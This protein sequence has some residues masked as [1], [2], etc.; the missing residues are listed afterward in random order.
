MVA[1]ESWRRLYPDVGVYHLRCCSSDH[2]PILLKTNVLVE[3]VKWGY[4]FK[5][6]A[7]WQDHEDYKQVIKDGWE[8]AGQSSVA[9]RIR[10]CDEKLR[11]WSK[12]TFGSL[13]ARRIKA[14]KAL[15]KIDKMRKNEAILAQRRVL[16]NELEDILL[17]EE[18]IWKQRSKNYW[19]KHGDK[20]TKFFHRRASDRR[21]KNMIK[22]LKD[23]DGKI[24]T[25]QEDIAR[26]IVNFY[27]K[28]YTSD[29]RSGSNSVIEAVPQKVTA[30]MNDELLKPFTREEI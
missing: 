9:G 25:D 20:N 28:L 2:N 8:A 18:F 3:D 11:N 12:Q 6:E 21:S 5:F 4:Y 17:Q 10:M 30:A 14:E 26:C 1:T 23:E 15:E 16:E 13:R 24:C 22:K 29:R 19:L 27:K 7:Y